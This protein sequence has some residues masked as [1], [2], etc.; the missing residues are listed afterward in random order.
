MYLLATSR[1]GVSSLQ[2]SKELG[3]TQTTAWFML[4]RLREAMGRD[5]DDDQNGFLSGIVEADETHVGGKESN[6]R[7]WKNLHAGRG[8]LQGPYHGSD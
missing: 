8:Q 6:K 5:D 7:E 2:L 3:V 1:K 4:Q